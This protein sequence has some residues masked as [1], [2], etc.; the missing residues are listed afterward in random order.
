MGIGLAALFA[1]IAAC[2]GDATGT[3]GTGTGGTSIFGTYTLQTINWVNL[4][5]VILQV[6]NDKEE[7]TA[8]TVG[9]NSDNTYNFSLSLRVTQAGT[10]TT[11]TDTGA[12]TFTA[13]RTTVQ[14]SDPGDGSGPFTGSISGNTLSIIDDGLEFVFGK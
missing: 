1:G 13:T 4:P 11:R 9:L 5:F 12:G 8:G 10:V 7:I 6:G 14:F 3:G 2:G